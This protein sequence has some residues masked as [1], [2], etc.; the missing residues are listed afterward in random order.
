MVIIYGA[1]FILYSFMGWIMESTLFTLRNHR[2]VNR[3]FLRGPYVPIYG[4][5]MLLILSVLYPF[6]HNIPVLFVLSGIVCSVLEFITGYVLEHLFKTRWWD[7][8]KKPFNLGG[9][10]CL[11]NSL[12]WCFLG[13]FMIV[14]VQ[15]VMSDIIKAIPF[16]YL[17]YLVTIILTI[18]SIDAFTTFISLLE[19]RKRNIEMA[20]LA[21]KIRLENRIDNNKYLNYLSSYLNEKRISY[22]DFYNQIKDLDLSEHNKEIINR[23]S[24]R[25]KHSQLQRWLNNYQDF[26]LYGRKNIKKHLEQRKKDEDNE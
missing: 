16:N 3:G 11:E 14:V 1:Y 20:L 24:E 19:V 2:F 13:T 10:I 4:F 17:T 25:K 6:H 18:M 22:Q 26:K 8:T 9:Y 7:Y 21:S 12:I 23:L 5:G 15:P